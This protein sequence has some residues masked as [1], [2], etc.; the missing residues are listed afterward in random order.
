MLP[1]NRGAVKPAPAL[2][3]TPAELIARL[4]PAI[5]ASLGRA[6]SLAAS[7]GV[8]LWLIGGA[9]RDLLLGMSPDRDIDLAVEGDAVDLA[10]AMADALGGQ[11]H[12]RHQEFGTATIALPCADIPCGVLMLDLA[13]T[14]VESYPQPA[15]L[16]VV[17]P[18]GIA[19]DLHR[20]DFSINAI[21]I[22]LL[23]DEDQLQAGDLLDPFDGRGDLA[24][25]RL[26]LLHP[27]SLRDDPTRILRGLRLASRLGL[28]PDTATAE[29]IAN[30][31]A[32]GYLRLL[33]PERIL[34]EICLALDEPRPDAALALS[35]AWGV[36]PQIAPG[37]AWSEAMAQRFA[38]SR[39]VGDAHRDVPPNPQ[40]P[41][42]NPQLNAGLLC[43]DLSA[44]QIASIAGRYPLPTPFARLLAELPKLRAT[45][46]TISADTRPGQ[47]DL[48]LRPYSDAAISVLHYAEAGLTGQ[49]AAHYLREI[50]PARSPLDGR[51]LQRLGVAPGPMIGKLL[52]ALRAAYLN[53]DVQTREQAEQWV[54]S[55]M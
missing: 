54:R 45:A 43:Y 15:M 5:T 22:A 53:G 35:D 29:Q 46:L 30:A 51:D 2:S 20:R 6:A 44:E 26:R 16:P 49:R 11:V 7:R 31:L 14:R 18:A 42:P 37:L 41:T 55:Q 1:L 47:I 28:R 23:A 27:T 21:T 48:L 17:R 40:P 39:Q 10:A 13:R 38:R 19:E 36:T 24:D 50:R 52:A 3:T 12:A 9:V 33:T 25:G 4:P 8:R 32:Q 34:G